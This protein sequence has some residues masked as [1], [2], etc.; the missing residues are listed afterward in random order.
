MQP[1]CELCFAKF[2]QKF[3]KVVLHPFSTSLPLQ[4]MELFLLLDLTNLNTVYACD[5][6][7]VSTR[8]RRQFFSISIIMAHHT[9][10]AIVDMMGM[11]GG[12]ER[13]SQQ[14]YNTYHSMR[15]TVF[16]VNPRNDLVINGWSLKKVTWDTWCYMTNCGDHSNSLY[17]STLI[18]HYIMCMVYLQVNQLILAK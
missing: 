12:K 6:S 8:H 3:M 10:T 2:K 13:E 1:T 18:P 9:S 15:T 5:H 7:S 14:V 17:M 4:N 11:E 16:I